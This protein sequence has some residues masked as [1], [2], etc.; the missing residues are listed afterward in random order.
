MTFGFITTLSY[1]DY[2]HSAHSRTILKELRRPRKENA[3]LKDHAK[4]KLR[5]KAIFTHIINEHHLVAS[6]EHIKVFGLACRK[7][8][9]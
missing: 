2:L 5:K 1:Q 7:N 4:K 9:L 6:G 3:T 8:A